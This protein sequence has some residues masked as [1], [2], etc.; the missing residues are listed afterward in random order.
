MAERPA[1]PGKAWVWK[2]GKWQR[3]ARPGPADQY[4]WSNN[5]GWVKKTATGGKAPSK[6]KPNAP[7]PN[8]A[9]DWLAANYGLTEALLDADPTDPKKGFTLREAFDQ[10]RREK[11]TDGMRAAQIISKTTFWQSNGVD[12][13]RRMALPKGQMRGQVDAMRLQLRD[14]LTAA[15]IDIPPGALNRIAKD[16]FIF[17]LNQSQINRAIFASSKSSAHAGGNTEQELRQFAAD[18]NVDDL[19]DDN[20]YANAAKAIALGQSNAD[21]FKQQLKQEAT[22]K[23]PYW[24]KQIKQGQTVASLA[25]AYVTTA[26]NLLEDP[27]ID[28]KSSVIKKALTRVD[29]KTG[30]V[31]PMS[32]W[33]F[34]KSVK[35]DPRWMTTKNAQSSI[36]DVAS[37]FLKSWG[38]L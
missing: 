32:L 29:S 10:I 2:D 16:A 19:H 15:G 30:Q 22:T 12:V 5:R 31:V 7:K 6:P 38:Q 36:T 8:P 17:G 23:S 33:E 24:A 25:N 28:L 26:Q 37:K 13:L 18:M 9:M 27:N 35:S 3:P 4:G 1:R 14:Q 34:E 11:I 21:S 20:W